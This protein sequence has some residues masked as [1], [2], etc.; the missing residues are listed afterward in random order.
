MVDII[1]T[2]VE[3]QACALH[4]K[5]NVGSHGGPPTVDRGSPS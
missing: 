4:D 3:G 5:A 1:S 2:C